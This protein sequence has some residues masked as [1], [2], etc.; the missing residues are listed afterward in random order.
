MY[1]GIEFREA[2]IRRDI[3]Y[4]AVFDP[5]DVPRLKIIHKLI[6]LGQVHPMAYLGQLDRVYN[7][8]TSVLEPLEVTITGNKIV[9]EGL[10]A[11][12][13]CMVGERSQM[14]GMYA[15]GTGTTDVSIRDDALDDELSRVDIIDEGGFVINRGTTCFFSVFFPKTIPNAVVSETA[16][17]DSMDTADDTMLLRTKFPTNEYLTHTKNLDNISVAHVIFSGSV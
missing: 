1:K 4:G 8:Q 9:N 15:I 11:L 17:L 12:A 16:I 6:Q 13:A 10:E 5:N 3:A 14:F 7:D 2:L